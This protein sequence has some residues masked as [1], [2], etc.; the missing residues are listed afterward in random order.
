M[1]QLVDG[2]HSV[3]AEHDQLLLLDHGELGQSIC[4]AAWLRQIHFAPRQSGSVSQPG[5]ASI[6]SDRRLES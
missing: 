3:L 4:P 1:M 5:G 6:T 2:G